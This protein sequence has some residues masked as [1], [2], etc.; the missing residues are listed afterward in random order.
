M[1]PGRLTDDYHHLPSSME[2]IV[3]PIA[4]ADAITTDFDELRFNAAASAQIVQTIP[5][6]EQAPT[7]YKLIS[8]PY[9]EPEHLLDLRHLDIQSALLAKA[10]TF[11]RPIDHHYATADYLKSFNWNATLAHLRLLLRSEGHT[12]R[13]QS[14]YTVIFRSQRNKG[15][16]LQRLHDLDKASHLEAATSG[17][18]LKYWFGSV[19]KD[20]RNLATCEY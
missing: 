1:A 12:W 16:D 19:D 8:S 3:S 6:K 17:G 15:I 13:E 14:F 18:L 7:N 4:P 11:M 2:N 20:E 10:L 5:L 9:N